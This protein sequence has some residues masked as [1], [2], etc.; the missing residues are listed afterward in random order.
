MEFLRFIK[1]Q[2]NRINR[3][4]RAAFIILLLV[5]VSIGYMWYIG[6]NGILIIAI[7]ICVFLLGIAAWYLYEAVETR[8]NLYKKIREIEAEEIVRKLRTGY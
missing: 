7:S 2:W 3:G 6:F 1:W 4:D 8:W 5:L